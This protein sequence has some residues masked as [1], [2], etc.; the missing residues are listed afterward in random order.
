[1]NIAL[2]YDRINKFGG[3]EQVL[4]AMHDIWPNAPLYTAFYNKTRSSWASDFDIYPSFANRFPFASLHHEWYPWLAPLAFESFS[5]DQYDVVISVTSAEAK[6]IITKP[7]TLHICYCL[8]PTRYLWSG[9][10]TYSEYP[11]LGMLGK[12]GLPIFKKY[13]PTLRQW[14]AIS[15]SRPDSYIAISELVKKRIE[16]YYQ[17][18][19]EAVIHPPVDTDTFTISTTPRPEFLPSEYYLVVSRLVGYKRIDLLIKAFNAMK[20]PLIVIGSGKELMYLRS[21]AGKTVSIITDKLTDGKLAQYYQHC[22]A[23]VF[24]AEED[25]GIAA[26]E[27]QAVGKAVIAYKNSGVADIVSEKTGVLFELQSIE[28]IIEAV[29]TFESKTFDPS[30][31]RSQALQFS[32]NAFQEKMISFLEKTKKR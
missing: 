26:A 16:T 1:M 24:A 30:Q 18:E 12:I 6:S 20:R 5:F 15:S 19:V 23:F 32:R 14:D 13:V 3:A 8:T 28:G 27:A 22:I 29:K 21:I 10:D 7:D 9:Y 2:V 25:F 17:R 4:L 31:C 11:G